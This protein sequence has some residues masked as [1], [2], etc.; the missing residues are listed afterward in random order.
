MKEFKV[1]KYI[2]LKLVN[3]KSEIYVNNELFLSCKKL[4]LQ[5]E[6][7]RVQDL[8]DLMSIDEIVEKEDFEDDEA[9]C[10]SPEAE[11]W[12]HCS[13]LQV[14][15]ENGYNQSLLHSNLAFPLLRIL[16]DVGDNLA[17]K[18]LKEEIL[19]RFE[20]GNE[21]VI[22][23]LLKNNSLKFFSYDELS[24][25]Y[26][27]FALP[28]ETSKL[29]FYFLKTLSLQNFLPAHRH[30]KKI[31][32]KGSYKERRKFFSRH[33]GIFTKNEL[34]TY[35]NLYSS[36]DP[37]DEEDEE[38]FRVL[39][40]LMD[41]LEWYYGEYFD[42]DSKL[43]NLLREDERANFSYIIT[44]SNYPYKRSYFN[45]DE[46]RR[47]AWQEKLYYDLFKGHVDS[48][49]LICED[50]HKEFLDKIKRLENFPKLENL[51]ILFSRTKD[52]ESLRHNLPLH[53][54]NVKIYIFDH[55]FPYLS[56]IKVN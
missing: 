33:I 9:V 44:N 20:S 39:D 10:I 40:I 45:D 30:V 46:V 53:L 18:T 13:N 19:E 31:L 16:A 43:N 47:R 24:Y 50:N 22:L 5:I 51:N 56:Q 34:M 7:S 1:N 25:I 12:G 38:K 6:K 52:Y 8:G 3:G 36:E 55:S 26:E 28:L 27:N 37:K 29:L 14:W 32:I 42:M 2:S 4:I 11:F 35:F 23:S 48:I 21:N 15:A 41:L 49:E 17:K 54:D